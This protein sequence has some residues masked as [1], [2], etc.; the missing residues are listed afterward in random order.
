MSD[1]NGQE[2]RNRLLERLSESGVATFERPSTNGRVAEQHDQKLT[3]ERSGLSP[4]SKSKRVAIALVAAAGVAAA[5]GFTV[6][7]NTNAV[8]ETSSSSAEIPHLMS[9]S[10]AACVVLTLALLWQTRVLLKHEESAL[11]NHRGRQPDKA[12]IRNRVNRKLA[13]AT[14]VVYGLFFFSAVFGR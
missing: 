6:M 5:A 14:L 11:E 12:G 4:A 13:A 8:E 1:S 9:L 2:T 10:A 3:N 7:A